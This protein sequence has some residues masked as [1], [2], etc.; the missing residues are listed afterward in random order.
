MEPTFKDFKCDKA[1][2]LHLGITAVVVTCMR[3]VQDKASQ[4]SN[5]DRGGDCEF[6]ALV[7]EI[8]AVDGCW[9]KKVIFLQESGHW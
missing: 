5:V 2:L 4:S 7:E 3:P 8:L 6:P 1:G 9:G